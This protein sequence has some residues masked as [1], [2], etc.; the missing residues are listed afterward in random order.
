MMMQRQLDLFAFLQ[1]NPG[2]AYT[3]KLS[4]NVVPA[5]LEDGEYPRAA[6][7]DKIQLPHHVQLISKNFTKPFFF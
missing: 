6:D 3:L 7:T 4:P 2:H 1:E 5:H